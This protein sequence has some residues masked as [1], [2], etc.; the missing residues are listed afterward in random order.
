MSLIGTIIGLLIGTYGEQI[1]KINVDGATFGILGCDTI[2]VE[3][4]SYLAFSEDGTFLFALSESGDK[5]KLTSFRMV[6]A[7]SMVS[8]LTEGVASDPCFLLWYRGCLLT[9]D[10][11]GGSVSVYPVTSDGVIQPARQ[12]VK[13]H[14]SGPN[15]E[16]Q[17]YSHIHMLKVYGD[18]L[19]ASDLGGDRIHVLSISG[20]DE[21]F[22]L[23]HIS[24]IRTAPGTGPRHFDI[25]ADGRYLYVLTELSSEIYVIRD[26][27]TVQKLYIGDREEPIQAGGD[28]RLSP[29]GRFLYASLRNGADKIVAMAVAADGTVTRAG[30][31][32]TALHCR[33][34]AIS[35]DGL[36]MIVPCKNSN[37]VQLFGIDPETGVPF[38]TGR[39]FEAQCPVLALPVNF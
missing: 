20:E 13:F 19:Y 24:D 7:C 25:S 37:V 16:R 8:E 4:G 18:R 38:D 15:K 21:N 39:G 22:T 12:V 33:N 3:N 5:S 6:G 9:A 27:E 14:C 10:Y 11:T 36:Q 23:D 28:L 32:A 26:G 29:D 2:S 34:F 17:P 35:S 30:D 31:C 1:Y